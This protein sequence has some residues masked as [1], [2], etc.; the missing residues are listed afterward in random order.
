MV[1]ITITTI[2]VF[3]G[4]RLRD[5]KMLEW[6]RHNQGVVVGLIIA[7]SLMV[8]T[9]GCD[10]QVTSPITGKMVTRPQLKLEVNIAVK[11]FEMELDN[12]QEQAALQF[13]SLDRQDE[14]KNK[15]YNFAAITA[16]ANTFN[17]TGLITLVG[18]LLG[19]GL[20]I[21]NRIKDKVI[22][23]RPLNGIIEPATIK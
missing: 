6:L 3:T 2:P 8:W 14:L 11:Q 4:T 9:Y 7:I 12:L 21:D 20:L 19:G 5:S 23:N 10:S 15:L 16:E 22:K 17:P 18:T 1:G 13:A